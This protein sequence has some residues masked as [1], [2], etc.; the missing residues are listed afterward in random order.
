DEWEYSARG[1]SGRVFPWGDQ[2]EPPAELPNRVLP[3]SQLAMAGNAG[4][5]GLGGNVAE[6]TES[7]IEGQ[8][9]L[10]GG[11]WLLPQPYFQRLALRRLASPGAVLD[12]S[13]RCAKSLESWPV[14]TD[15][16][17]AATQ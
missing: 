3:V 9:V 14:S 17:S 6:W 4:S 12:G 16:V 8:P 7:R 2:P 11:S 5:H 13:F 15:P 1:P 10:R